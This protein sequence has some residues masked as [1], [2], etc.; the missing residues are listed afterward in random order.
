MLANPEVCGQPS[1]REVVLQGL[2]FQVQA[3]SMQRLVESQVLSLATAPESKKSGIKLTIRDYDAQA[4]SLQ[5]KANECFAQAVAFN[6]LTVAAGNAISAS[7][8]VDSAVISEA[9]FHKAEP[10]SIPEPE[11][12]I[13]SRSPYS[14]VNPIP[15]DE[16]L[17]DGV[18]YKIQLGAFSK[19]LPANAFKGLTPLSSEKLANG[20]AKYYV[21]LFRRFT[22]GD[23]ALRKVREYGFKDAYMVAFYNRKIINPERAKQLE[24]R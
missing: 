18:V 6:G 15:V 17:P 3:D 5:K 11:F 20:I 13:L 23:D 2:R 4:V 9:A 10:Q 8:P 19:P 7:E 21:G 12:A 14:A 22:D 1:C 24:G 16:P